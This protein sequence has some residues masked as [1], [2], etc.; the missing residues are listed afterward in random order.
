M[1]FQEN[2]L[3]RLP[4]KYKNAKETIQKSFERAKN[5]ILTVQKSIENTFDSVET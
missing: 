5:H 3:L 4:F 2:W 1:Q